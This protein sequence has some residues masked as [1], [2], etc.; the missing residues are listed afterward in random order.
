[1]FLFNYRLDSI[2]QVLKWSLQT[3][4]EKFN[5][6]IVD[7]DPCCKNLKSQKHRI[8]PVI[9]FLGKVQTRFYQQL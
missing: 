2:D 7:F 6:E 1:M 9:L 8:I 5:R 4:G 3:Y